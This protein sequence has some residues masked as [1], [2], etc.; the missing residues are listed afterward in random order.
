MFHEMLAEEIGKIKEA[1]GE[2]AYKDGKYELATDLFDK[3]ISNDELEEFLT[4][5]AYENLD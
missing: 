3:I 4:L 5:R 1:V 2:E